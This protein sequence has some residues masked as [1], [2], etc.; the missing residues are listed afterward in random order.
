MRSFRLAML[1]SF[2]V[3]SDYG[4]LYLHLACHGHA[5]CKLLKRL[6]DRADPLTGQQYDY[7]Y[8]KLSL[9]SAPNSRSLLP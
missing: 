2:L 9:C 5:F 6:V 4:V 1:F 3:D 8:Y 7:S